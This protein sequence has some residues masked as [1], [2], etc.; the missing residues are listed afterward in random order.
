MGG[1]CLSNLNLAL[2]SGR[3]GLLQGPLALRWRPIGD[4]PSV[5][6]LVEERTNVLTSKHLVFPQPADA[7]SS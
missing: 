6:D 1:P 4:A 2:C 7:V 5:D 3:A